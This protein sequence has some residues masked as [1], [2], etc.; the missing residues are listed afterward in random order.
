MYRVMTRMVTTTTHVKYFAARFVYGRVISLLIDTNLFRRHASIDA[1]S[2]PRHW[3]KTTKL[4]S[5]IM[6]KRTKRVAQI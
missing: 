6:S 1:S 4:S 2:V 5:E 3:H